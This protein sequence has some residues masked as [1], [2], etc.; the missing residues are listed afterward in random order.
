MDDADPESDA[1]AGPEF[2]SDGPGAVG[3]NERLSDGGGGGAHAGVTATY[4]SRLPRHDAARLSHLLAAR[5]APGRPERLPG[6]TF[7]IDRAGDDPSAGFARDAQRAGPDGIFEDDWRAQ[8]EERRPPAPGAS[9]YFGVAD[10]AGVPPLPDPEPYH[11]YIDDDCGWPR[12][13]GLA[14]RTAPGD[15]RGRGNHCGIRARGA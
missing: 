13:E 12:S 15:L 7:D 11:D 3:R 8:G 1:F 10:D 14:G 5:P 6:L 4:L 9:R 2:E